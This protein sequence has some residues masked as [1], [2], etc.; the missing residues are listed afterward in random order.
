MKQHRLAKGLSQP[1]LAALIGVSDNRIYHWETK[2][3]A[4][5]PDRAIQL[6]DVLECEPEELDIYIS[7]GI[8]ALNKARAKGLP[9]KLKVY[10]GKHHITGVELS[11]RTGLSFRSLSNYFMGL[12]PPPKKQRVIADALGLN[13]RD[14]FPT[15]EERYGK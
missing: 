10:C 8:E 7:G 14:L 12:I 13:R 11:R 2:R 9:T 1:K 6:G 15:E 3:S 5:P 4:V